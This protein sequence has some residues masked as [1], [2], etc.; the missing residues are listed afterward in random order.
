MH[1]KRPATRAER[2]CAG[3]ADLR[4]GAAPP[5]RVRAVSVLACCLSLLSPAAW[6]WRPAELDVAPGF[7]LTVFAEG[8]DNARQMAWA[9]GVLFVGSRTAG[10]VYALPDRNGDGRADEVITIASGLRRPSGIA[11]RGK[12]LYIADVSRILR[13]RN[14]VA[15]PRADAPFEVVYDRFPNEGH[16]GWKY[17]RFAPDGRLTVPVGAPCNRCDPELP[18]A[19]IHLLD[20]ESGRLETIARGVRNTVG[21]DYHPVTGELWFTENG[22]DMM[23]DEYPPEELNRLTRFGQHFGWPYVHGDGGLDPEFGEGH[24]PRDYVM[25]VA[26]MPAHFAPLGMTFYRGD[27]FPKKYRHGVII[28]E[29]G[30]WNRS[31]PGGYRVTAVLL[32]ARQQPVGYEVLVQGWLDPGPVGDTAQGHSDTAVQGRSEPAAQD[33]SDRGSV[34]VTVH[35][36]PAD[37][38]ELPDGSLL[39]ADDHGGRIYRLAYTG[40]TP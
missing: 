30:S 14:L 18:F 2:A 5:V 6:G 10:N 36:R 11:L 15:A 26:T 33:G 23:G 17:L 38:L 31:R 1:S 12:D 32:D 37:V 9:D 28:A 25:P 19:A 7:E 35:G 13:M 39:I 21:F 24:D 3:T 20:L 16:H 27:A 34:A 4:F 40:N 29:H 22:T 8:V